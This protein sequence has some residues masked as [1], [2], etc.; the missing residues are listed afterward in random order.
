[1]AVVCNMAD[2]VHMCISNPPKHSVSYIV[3]F[4]KGKSAIG[5]A[6]K[7]SG[8]TRNITGENFWKPG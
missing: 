7:F 3:G 6:R 2:R 5:I 4:I 1:M 8:K